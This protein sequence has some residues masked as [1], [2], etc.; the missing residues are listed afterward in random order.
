MEQTKTDKSMKRRVIAWTIASLAVLTVLLVEVTLT[1][2]ARRGNGTR[3]LSTGMWYNLAWVGSMYVI[4]VSLYILGIKSM[5]YVL[6]G[7]VGF[8]MIPVP[9]ICIIG[10]GAWYWY[11]VREEVFYVSLLIMSILSLCAL[12]VNVGWFIACFGKKRN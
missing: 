1:P 12:A 4:P 11:L 9:V 10:A 5:R 8:W 7:V 6:A 2:L 3:F